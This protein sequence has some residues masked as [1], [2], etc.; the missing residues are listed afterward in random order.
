MKRTLSY[1]NGGEKYLLVNNG[2]IKNILIDA[3]HEFCG[4]ICNLNFLLL[5]YAVPEIRLYYTEL[6]P[7][8]VKLQATAINHY[9]ETNML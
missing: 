8:P 2:I 4:F 7:S 5:H 3:R 6:N 9:Q 1:V